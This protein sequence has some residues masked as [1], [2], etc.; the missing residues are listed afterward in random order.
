MKSMI[1]CQG[2]T[3]QFGKLTAVNEVSFEVHEGEVVG[4]LGPNGAG[5][6]T[7]IRM[8]MGLTFPT[9][10]EVAILDRDPVRSVETRA[11]I[12]YCPGELRLDGRL[13]VQQ[14]F[15][16]WCVMRQG[17]DRDWMKR[18]IERFDVDVHKPV[19]SLST[20]NR[21]KVG[22]VGAF[23]A[24]PRLL[25]LDE[26][27]NGLD[28]LMQRAFVETVTE[29]CND[30]TTV[31]LSSHVLAEVDRL[32]QRLV[33]LRRGEVVADTTVAEVH[34]S[35]VQSVEVLLDQD[36]IGEDF[37]CLPGASEVSVDGRLV[38]L[39]WKGDPK[40]LLRLLTTLSVVSVRIMD[41][42]LESVFMDYYARGAEEATK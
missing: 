38:R 3:K 27:T 28:P 18:L 7:T 33:V 39:F 31:L 32:A 23:M 24:R 6:S 12:G 1:R 26:P 11:E 20:G 25:I 37:S 9:S 2:L 22:L 17:V 41:P 15:D 29:A 4:Y 5:K 19:R 13:S 42:D 21:R 34:A 16:T 30:G 35:A 14:T 36:A 8:L 40:H 10:G